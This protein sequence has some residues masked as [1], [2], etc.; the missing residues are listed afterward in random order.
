MM[1]CQLVTAVAAL[2]SHS[3]D[4]LCC[5]REKNTVDILRGLCTIEYLASLG[6][7]LHHLA[8]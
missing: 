2:C 1:L 4:L 8:K 3:V 5:K 7:R 6:Y